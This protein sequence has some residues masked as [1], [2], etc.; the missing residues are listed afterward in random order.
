MKILF[1]QHKDFINGSGGTEKICTFLANHFATS[2]QNKV[3]IATN[4]DISGKAVFPLNVNI[5]VTNIFDSSV[6]QKKMQTSHNYKGKNPFQW[7]NYKIKK[8]QVKFKNK[9]L[10]KNMGGPDGL[11]EFNLKKR[12]E[13]WKKYIDHAEPNIIITMSIASLLEITYQNEYNIPIINSV[14]G[15]PDYDYSDILWHRNEKEMSLLKESYKKLSAIQIL[16]DSYKD[17][18]PETF[19]SKIFTIPNPVPHIEEKQI[20]NHLKIKERYKIINIASLVC[21]CKQ[22][23]L[24]IKIFTKIAHKYPDWDMEFWGTGEDYEILNNQINSLG[25]QD[26]IF[27]RGFT[28]C[29]LD[30]LKKSDIFIFPSKYEGF[31]LAL[32]EAMSAGLP[33]I[34]FNTCSGVN[35]LIIDKENGFLPVHEDEMISNLEILIQDAALRQVLGEN[36]HFCMKKYNKTIVT[37]QWE[38]LVNSVF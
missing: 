28:D 22:Q 13:A 38:A 37:Q 11:Y 4:Q 12:S 15:R 20:V 34:G 1:I 10:N 8:K 27:L 9:L 17:Y 23:H 18:L 30:E 36:A 29:P 5:K 31:P 33:S 7:I 16:F 3:E 21:D 6:I 32:T 14:N 2:N 25:L 24:A 26:R 35:E 19:H